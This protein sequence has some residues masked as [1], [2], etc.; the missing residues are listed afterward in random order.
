MCFGLEEYCFKIQ[1]LVFLTVTTKN[2]LHKKIQSTSI[3]PILEY[4]KRCFNR[5]KPL[6]KI[7]R[8][9]LCQPCLLCILAQK[10]IFFFNKLYISKDI[11]TFVLK[12]KQSKSI[13]FSLNILKY[14]NTDFIQLCNF[15]NT[16][17]SK[18]RYFSGI[19]LKQNN[20]FVSNISS[21]CRSSRKS[22]S[23]FCF[24]CC[25]FFHLTPNF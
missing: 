8:V 21:S 13:K 2:N 23:K 7:G 15:A 24:K 17:F 19:D 12:W 25:F 4:W 3:G 6:V 11:S 10:L 5:L 14:Q 18:W 16:A 20:Y 22:T 1:Q 9:N